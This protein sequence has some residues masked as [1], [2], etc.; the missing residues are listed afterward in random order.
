MKSEESEEKDLST[1]PAGS[2]KDRRPLD[3]LFTEKI[4]DLKRMAAEAI[5]A[6]SHASLRATELLNEAYIKLS[7]GNPGDLGSR[8]HPVV[9]TLIWQALRCILIDR[10]R[11]RT[12]PI[13]GG[14]SP[15][16]P[17]DD[18]RHVFRDVS[19]MESEDV[20]I[21]CKG[22]EEL[23]L[24]DPRQARIVECRFGVGM[25]IAETASYLDI[26]TITVSRDWQEAKKFLTMRLRPAN[27][28]E[29]P[30]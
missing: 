22:I 16:V 23:K 19:A 5:R 6:D 18:A 15:H 21:L 10:A 25:T 29:G 2:P 12:A 24:A 11:R 26:S 3:V 9:A 17:L 27:S 1:G 14:D 4:A 30:T 20:E 13:R 7:K 8:C 28:R